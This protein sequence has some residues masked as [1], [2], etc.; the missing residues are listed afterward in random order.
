MP[1]GSH[2]PSERVP[3]ARRGRG[4]Q[5]P[6]IEKRAASPHPPVDP[7]ARA[8]APPGPELSFGVRAKNVLACAGHMRGVRAVP[9][10]PNP[11]PPKPQNARRV[12]S[13]AADQR[14]LDIGVEVQR[15]VNGV[16]MGV[17]E[18][19]IPFLTLQ[20]LAKIAGVS[21]REISELNRQW[22]EHFGDPIL[23]KQRPSFIKEL[24]VN[25][26]YNERKLYIETA[27]DL[28]PHHAYPDVVCM[29]VLEHHAFEA[30]GGRNPIA[31]ENFRR[32]AAYGLQRLI[33]EALNY[34]PVDR[35]RYYHERVSHLRNSNPDGFFIVFHEV[36]SAIVDLINA[37]LAVNRYTINDRSIEQRW[38]AYW[39]SA[40]HDVIYGERR[41]YEYTHPS[42]HLQIDN[43][44]QKPWA[45]PAAAL[46]EFRRWLKHEYLPTKFPKYLLSRAHLSPD[47]QEAEKIAIV[48]QPAKMHMH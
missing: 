23:L 40:D 8:F 2:G 30:K 20:G 36:S 24:L 27:K 38:A 29:A 35:W 13:P 11:D 39:K 31:I 26:G 14:V 18:N 43:D 32:L 17:L 6:G 48:F 1:D 45:Y 42:Y 12:A 41:Q 37:N 19:G 7:Q 15:E 3:V 5:T 22:E 4:E 28:A 34:A 10:V 21:Q 16:E 33:Y 9:L 44:P 46:A 25:H 47:R